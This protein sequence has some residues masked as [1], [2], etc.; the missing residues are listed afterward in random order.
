MW[1]ASIYACV[2]GEELLK[3]LQKHSIL[4]RISLKNEAQRLKIDMKLTKF[5]SN[6]ILCENFD[7]QKDLGALQKLTN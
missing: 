1:V 4:S 6:M 3:V 2:N 5:H 7:L